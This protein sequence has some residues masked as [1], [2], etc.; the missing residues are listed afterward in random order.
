MIEWE[1]F[2]NISQNDLTRVRKQYHL[3]VQNVALVGRSFREKSESDENATLQWV[4]GF[5]RMAGRWVE[6]DIVS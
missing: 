6:G 1:N 5:W 3:A 4:P 2:S